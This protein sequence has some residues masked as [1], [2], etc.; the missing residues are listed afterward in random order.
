MT[1][2]IITIGD[3]ILIGQIVDT[4]STFI[5][6]ELNK[7]GIDVR[8][9]TSIQDEKSHILASLKNASQQSEIVIITGGLGPTKDDITKQSLCEYFDDELVLSEE[10]LKN[11]T[12]I[13]SA[14]D[15]LPLSDMNRSQALLPSKADLLPNKYG[16]ASG[17]WF[18]EEGTIYI[19]LPGVPFEMKELMLSEVLPRL[20]QH[21]DRTYILHKTVLTYGLG[22][23]VIAEKIAAWEEALPTFI[24]LA[25]LPGLGMVRLRLSARGLDETVLKDELTKQISELRN[26]L[27]SSIKGSEEELPLEIQIAKSLTRNQKTLATIESCTGGRIASIFTQNPGASAYF[28]GS[29]VSYAT[30]VKT[31]VL[32][33]SAALIEKYSVVSREVTEVMARKGQELFKTDY[34]LAT[35]GNAGPTKGDSDAAVGT[36]FIALA[37]PSGVRSFGYNMGNHREKVLGKATQKALEIL[38]EELR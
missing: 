30:A 17:M 32:H 22:E 28:N 7:I 15:Q 1:A 21:F 10:A 6:N 12:Q 24:K 9:I 31:D 36:V 25:Y 35:T 38:W 8:Q 4:N 23:S 29:I 19:S 37:T 18:D 16:T 3:E 11:I 13:F 26:L 34:V 14:Y 27:G 33:I 2:E 5:S 20:G